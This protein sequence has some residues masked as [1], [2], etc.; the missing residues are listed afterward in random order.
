MFKKLREKLDTLLHKNKTDK[1]KYQ[2]L[3]EKFL[4]KLDKL[5]GKTDEKSKQ[6]IFILKK[7]IQKIDKKL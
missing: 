5:D 1:K 6:E 2:E 7:T 3:R 4:K